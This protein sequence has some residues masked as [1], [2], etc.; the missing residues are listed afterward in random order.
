MRVKIL[1]LN[2]VLLLYIH[3]CKVYQPKVL[4]R[5]VKYISEI[6]KKKYYA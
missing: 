2:L 4:A 1:G 6:R 5:V 3:V